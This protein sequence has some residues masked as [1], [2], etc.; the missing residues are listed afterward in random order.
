[1]TEPTVELSELQLL[2][3]KA[4][5]AA[6]AGDASIHLAISQTSQQRNS[7]IGRRFVGLDSVCAHVRVTTECALAAA[8]GGLVSLAA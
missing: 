8:T 5:I 7:N 6:A 3:V 1:M 2:H 4:A